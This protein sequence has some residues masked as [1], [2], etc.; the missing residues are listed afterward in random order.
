M[1]RFLETLNGSLPARDPT[2]EPEPDADSIDDG[3]LDRQRDTL[4]DEAAVALRDR[5]WRTR[6]PWR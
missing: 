3:G 2:A 1:T 6:P 4:E 5:Y